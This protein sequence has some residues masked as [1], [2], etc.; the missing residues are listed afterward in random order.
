MTVSIIALKGNYLK[1]LS[2]IFE[3]FDYLDTNENVSFN[4]ALDLNNYLWE[5]YIEFSK[6]DLSLKGVWFCDDYTIIC[7]PEM[8]DST[9]EETLLQISNTLNTEVF[10]FIIQT[11][12]ATFGYAKFHQNIQRIFYMS[13]GIIIKNEGTPLTEETS[14]N[15]SEKIFIDDILNLSKKFGID[16]EGYNSNH[17][18]A[19]SLT[20]N[21]KLTQE[22][23]EF[24]TSTNK[25]KPWWKIW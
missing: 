10:S 23:K 22:L 20:Y 17:F 16:L 19:K 25:T 14:V 4:N 18:I 13:D 12:S 3:S 8:I 5:N 24:E 11:T 9:N 6:K 2:T 21:D 7:D 15:I 1:Y